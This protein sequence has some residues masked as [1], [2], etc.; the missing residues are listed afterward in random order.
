MNF[1]KPLTKQFIVNSIRPMRLRLDKNILYKSNNIIYDELHE[2]LFWQ[3]ERNN[4]INRA[5]TFDLQN[6]LIKST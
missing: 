1:N 2:F 6:E 3:M 5:L 4:R